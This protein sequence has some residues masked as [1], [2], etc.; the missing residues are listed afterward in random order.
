MHVQAEKHFREIFDR[1]PAKY[2]VG[3][4]AG[5]P[6]G[7][8]ENTKVIRLCLAAS[9]W[10]IAGP[11][12]V[13]TAVLIAAQSNSLAESTASSKALTAYPNTHS[14]SCPGQP[15][16]FQGQREQAEELYRQLT[17]PAARRRMLNNCCDPLR[18]RPN[19]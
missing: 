13:L 8:G 7:T 3:T 14:C 19:C 5:R 9:R 6:A 11:A 17:Q 18:F 16:N 10:R 1:D 2:S 15:G 4:C 12:I